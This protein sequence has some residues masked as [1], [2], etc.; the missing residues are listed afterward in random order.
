MVRAEHSAE[1]R[2]RHVRRR[3]PSEKAQTAITTKSGLT[4]SDGWMPMPAR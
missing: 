2:A 1:Q 4:N 3:A